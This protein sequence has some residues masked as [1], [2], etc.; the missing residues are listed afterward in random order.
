MIF[1]VNWNANYD[2]VAR[3]GLFRRSLFVGRGILARFL[4]RRVRGV[5]VGVI[6]MAM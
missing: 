3:T 2:F 5:L 1:V 4:P 6:L